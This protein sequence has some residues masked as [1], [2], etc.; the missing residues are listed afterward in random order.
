LRIGFR[1]RCQVHGSRQPPTFAPGRGEHLGVV[2]PYPE[3]Y[4]VTLLV[5]FG[6]VCNRGVEGQ[7]Q[8]V[9]WRERWRADLHCH[10]G[11]SGRG[12]RMLEEGPLL[13]AA[14]GG[15]FAFLKGGAV[16]RLSGGKLLQ[17]I[18][19]QRQR[20]TRGRSF[21]GERAQ[22]RSHHGQE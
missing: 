4:A 11:R 7:Q 17:Q 9:A 1:E 22:R 20:R 3:G 13:H 2:D 6:A 14:G 18:L 5:E 21:C 8:D 15:G 10:A 16:L 19:A 12:G